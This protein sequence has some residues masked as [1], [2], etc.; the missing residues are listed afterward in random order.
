[1][2]F[3]EFQAAVLTTLSKDYYPQNH[4]IMHAIYGISTEAGEL[5]DALKKATYYGKPLDKVNL[6]E[7][8]GDL[9][10]YVAVLCHCCRWDL[11]DVFDVV[12]KKLRTRYPEGFSQHHALNRDL[13]A[14]REVLE[15][16]STKPKPNNTDY[17]TL[18]YRPK[19]RVIVTR[20]T[21]NSD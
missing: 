21:L 7:E 15:E 2:N 14:E 3:K 10:Y 5:L 16:G 17:T 18:D 19:K 6:K 9:L 13:Q 8:T 11:E 12:I 4:D 1:M 20:R